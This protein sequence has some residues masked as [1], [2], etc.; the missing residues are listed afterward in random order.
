MSTGENKHGSWLPKWNPKTDEEKNKPAVPDGT[1]S[2]V[3]W[4]Q[5]MNILR[6]TPIGEVAPVLGATALVVFFAISGVLAWVVL[7]FGFMWTLFNFLFRWRRN[8]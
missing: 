6:Q 8:G 7:I 1:I 2:P 4:L 5:I 3:K